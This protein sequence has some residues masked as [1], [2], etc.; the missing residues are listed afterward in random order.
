MYLTINM[1][2][3]AFNIPALRPLDSCFP[4]TNALIKNKFTNK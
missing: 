4:A 3:R 2:S 1:D